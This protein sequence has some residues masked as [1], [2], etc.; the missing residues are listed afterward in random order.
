MRFAVM[1]AC[2]AWRNF[3]AK[4]WDRACSIFASS[5][6]KTGQLPPSSSVTFLRLSEHMRA[7]TFPTRVEPVK[8][9]LLTSGW[10]QSASLS[11]G[12][13]SRSVVSTFN[14]PFGKPALSARYA[15]AR[16]EMGVSGDGLTIIV[17]PAASAAPALRRIMAI[18]KFH[19]TSAA[20][21]PSGCL[22]VKMRRFG[23]A[24]VKTDP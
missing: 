16:T 1:Q 18:G 19:G 15:S 3:S 6:I 22:I 13:L 9:T 7:T 20:A 14:A 4:T 8:V 12:V 5:K 21:T 10:R 24:G 23:S 17:H 2:P 11:S